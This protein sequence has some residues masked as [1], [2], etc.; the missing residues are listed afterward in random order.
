[1]KKEQ[2]ILVG[3]GGHC[4]SC[5]DV[6]E[7]EGKFNIVGIIDIK[8]KI[9]EKILGY[10]II[11]CD[12]DLNKL[13]KIFGNYL[14]TIGQIKTPEIRIKLFNKIKAIGGKLPIIKSPLSYVSKHAFV[15]EGTIIMHNAFINANAKIGKNCIINTRAL[16]EHDVTIGNHCHI[17]TNATING[18][19]EIGSGTFYGSSA[20]CK[21]Y[22]KIPENSFIKANSTVKN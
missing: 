2:L 18:G 6:I 14:I 11:G 20:V 19:V 17:S 8:E 4:K 15:D 9:G 22:I 21:E 3:G 10:Q 1:M 12:D 13:I 7:A 16:I 5:I